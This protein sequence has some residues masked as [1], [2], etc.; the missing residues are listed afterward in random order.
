M[1]TETAAPAIT[2]AMLDEFAR[3][4]KIAIPYDATVGAEMEDA[5]RAAVGHLEARL[6]LALIERGF[7]WRGSLG[8]DDGVTAPIGPVSALTAVDR[9]L[10]D[11]TTAPLDPAGFRLDSSALRTRF[12]AGVSYDDLL[13]FAFVAGFGPDWSDAP[14]DLR[15]AALM[16]AAH[17]YDNRHATTTSGAEALPLSIEALIQPWRPARIGFGSAA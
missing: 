12:C 1:L 11:G 15:R 17:L 10:P 14:P 8:G 7:R 4:L 5:L 9:V 3:H 16:T 6:G 2:A 13:D